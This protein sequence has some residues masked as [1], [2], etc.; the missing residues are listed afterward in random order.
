MMGDYRLV[1]TF[2]PERYSCE[3]R[4]IERGHVGTVVPLIGGRFEAVIEAGEE[5]ASIGA[6]WTVKAAV[7]QVIWYDR[8]MNQEAE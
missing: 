2:D 5:A 6:V 3:V 8:A 4:H 7:E 1:W